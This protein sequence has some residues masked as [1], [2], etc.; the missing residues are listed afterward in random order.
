MDW[1]WEAKWR[2]RWGM[3]TMFPR[4][5][6]IMRWVRVG[7]VRAVRRRVGVTG[8][9]ELGRKMRRVV[10]ERVLRREGKLAGV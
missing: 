4:G 1:Y 7:V 3:E 9:G 6:G 2:G 5:E 8:L 10:M